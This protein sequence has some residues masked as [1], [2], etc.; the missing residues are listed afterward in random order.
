[1]L[2]C[3]EPSDLDPDRLT[4]GALDFF[5]LL[6]RELGS[7]AGRSPAAASGGNEDPL[8]ADLVDRLRHRGAEVW[9][10][11]AGVLDIV[12][13]RPA[14]L[15][16][17]GSA[18]AV[19]DERPAPLA[20]ESDGTSRYGSMSVRE[21]SRLR[22]QVL[23]RMGW[24]YMPLWTIE[25]FTDPEGCAERA[26][27]LIGLPPRETPDQPRTRKDPAGMRKDEQH[28]E[29]GTTADE[30][31][32]AGDSSPVI[33]RTAGEDDPRSWGDTESNHDEWLKEQRPPHW[34]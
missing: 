23:E 29:G 18:A 25:V 12:A 15:R 21:R 20:I 6:Q 24:R 5:E 4:T 17:D 9:D 34:G 10:H 27:A 30:P 13:V 7:D 16:A 3:F 28:P 11:Y 1:V 2:T 14:D 33:P 32:R 31:D 19:Q 8:V 26:S 22:P